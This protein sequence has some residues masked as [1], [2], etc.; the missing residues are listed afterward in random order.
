MVGMPYPNIMS[1][2]LQEKM[3]Y[4]D[5]TLVSTPVPP[6]AAATPRH[7]CLFAPEGWTC[8]HTPVVSAAGA[9]EAHW[10]R[11]QA[12][13]AVTENPSQ[14]AGINHDGSS[15]PFAAQNPRPGPPWEGA[16]GEPVHEGCQP[17][18]R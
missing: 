1:P 18:H 7:V 4:L 5:Q 14:E 11:P 8:L 3:A 2:E 17:V 16:G 10:S 13:V 12:S 9:R 15:L 6:T